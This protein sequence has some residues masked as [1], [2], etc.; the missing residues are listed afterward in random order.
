MTLRASTHLAAFEKTRNPVNFIR[1]ALSVVGLAIFNLF[2]VVP[3][4][5]YAALLTSIYAVALALY[6]AGIAV[7]ASG[8]AGANELVLDG[9]LRHVVIGDDDDAASDERTKITIDEMGVHVHQEKVPEKVEQGAA[10]GAHGDDQN[11]DADDEP[12]ATAPVIKR[13]EAVAG[14]GV[15]IS[16]DL[17]AGSRTTQTLFGL[18]MVVGAICL[19]L[20]CMVVTKYTVIVVKRYIEMNFSLLKGH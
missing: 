15:H 8:L 2:M 20:L 9:P 18:S 3:A 13:A 12:R 5:V 10:A 16:T 4:A 14:R 11:V 17:D 19:F 6:I 1:M 7:T